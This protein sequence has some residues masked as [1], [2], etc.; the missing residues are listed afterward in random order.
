MKKTMSLLG[1]LLVFIT[2]IQ[3]QQ[4]PPIDFTAVQEWPSISRERI[5]NN[6]KYF[7]HRIGNL[8]GSGTMHVQSLDGSWKFEKAGV[9][10]LTFSEDSRRAFFTISDTLHILTL[11]RSQVQVIPG[12]SYSLFNS[13]GQ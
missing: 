10:E 3:A 8:L 9:N 4:K 1:L 7:A 12:V 6:G 13:N 11:G 2:G 5:S